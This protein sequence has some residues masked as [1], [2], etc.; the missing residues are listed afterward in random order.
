MGRRHGERMKRDGEGERWGVGKT[1]IV[2]CP[3]LRY[4]VLFADALLGVTNVEVLAHQVPE[5]RCVNF[6]ART[7][8]RPWPD[9]ETRVVVHHRRI[10]D[11]K[12]QKLEETRCIRLQ[13]LILNLYCNSP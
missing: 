11:S 4:V 6:S 9:L 7:R 1:Y 12:L 8:H 5:R 10:V 13:L 2:I 3:H